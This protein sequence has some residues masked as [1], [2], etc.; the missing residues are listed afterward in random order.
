[1]CVHTE[2]YDDCPE[3]RE[4]L[5]LRSE[6]ERL[7]S[8]LKVTEECFQLVVGQRDA[9]ERMAEGDGRFI[10]GLSDECDKRMKREEVLAAALEEL[11]V[12]D[13]IDGWADSWHDPNCRK[14]KALGRELK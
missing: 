4:L 5:T 11:A 2:S 6:V 14:C 9:A 12:C 8:R 7:E 13:V 10:R 3:C 1:M